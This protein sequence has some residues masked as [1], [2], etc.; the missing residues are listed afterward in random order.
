MTA[1]QH[2]PQE[3]IVNLSTESALRLGARDIPTFGRIFFPRT[4]RQESPEFHYEMSYELENPANRLVGFKVFRDGAKTSL[5]R[6]YAA[7]RIGNCI[8]RTIMV[9]NINQDKAI[10]T[11]RW[12]KKAVDYN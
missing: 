7:K 1:P 4:V 12:L 5:L 11:I 10:H 6:L 9:V 3:R 8:S 2:L